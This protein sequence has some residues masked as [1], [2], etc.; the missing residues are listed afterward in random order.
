MNTNGVFSHNTDLWATPQWLFDELDAKYHFTVD[1]CAT[2]D[3][4][5][6]AK[7]YTEAQDGLAQEWT[8]NVWCNP[9]YGRQI[10]KWVKK[11]SECAADVVVMLLPA[12]TD[13]AWFHDYCLRGG[14][15]TFLRGRLKFGNATTGAPFPSMIVV[16]DKN[17]VGGSNQAPPKAQ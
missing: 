17:K 1:V 12:R 8:G 10:A 2:P 6:C 3:N 9:P 14:R 13:T 15:V 11:A 7:Y 4:A 16:F 5:K